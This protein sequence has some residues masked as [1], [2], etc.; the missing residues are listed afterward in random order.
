MPIAVLQSNVATSNV[1]WPTFRRTCVAASRL[2]AAALATI[3]LLVSSSSEG[4]ELPKASDNIHGSTPSS[5]SSGSSRGSRSTSES[6]CS[7]SGT[8]LGEGSDAG[9]QFFWSVFL[10]PFWLPHAV[11]EAGPEPANGWSLAP[12]PYA[13]GAPAYFEHVGSP[14]GSPAAAYGVWSAAIADS[15]PE[16]YEVAADHRRVVGLQLAAEGMPPV[17]GIGRL[18]ASA[19]FQ[20]AYRFELDAAYALYLER[21]DLVAASSAWSGA[22]LG[23]AHAALQFARGEHVQ[24]RAGIGMRHWLDAQGSSFGLDLLYGIDVFWGRPVTT[25]LEVT[26]GSLGNAWVAEPRG[27]V[28]FVFGIGEIFAGYD[29]VWIGGAGPTAYLGGPVVG[30]RAYF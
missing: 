4:G 15:H 26:G 30:M 10:S 6:C 21:G 5:G 23:H 17:A 2:H 8:S 13:D 25:C 16:G 14:P 29:A 12:S 7:S 19:R 20:T 24:F 28:G 22:W 3:A 9:W 27:T 18:Q 1:A 11:I